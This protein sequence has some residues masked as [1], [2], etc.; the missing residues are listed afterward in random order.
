MAVATAAAKRWPD[1]I[2][3]ADELAGIEAS[4]GKAIGDV[5]ELVFQLRAYNAKMED[6]NPGTAAFQEIAPTFEDIGRVWAALTELETDIEVLGQQFAEAIKLVSAYPCYHREAHYVP[7][8][9]AA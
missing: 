8:P 6:R 1:T 5:E 3:T 4:M 2:P 7:K 9:V